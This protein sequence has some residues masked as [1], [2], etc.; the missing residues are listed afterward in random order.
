M[1]NV[2][3]AFNILDSGENV[4]E[5]YARLSVHMVFD[6]KLDLTWKARLVAKGHLTPDTIDSTYA[7]VVSRKT[8]G[9]ALTYAE[10]MGLDIWAA[11]IMNAF[12]QAPATEKYYVE[13]GP[14]FGNEYMGKWGNCEKSFAWH[15]IFQ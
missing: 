3:V 9:I 11:D 1:N 4:P 5:G 15:E 13:C 7:G 6:V 12:V 8:V 14:E 10:L 2:I